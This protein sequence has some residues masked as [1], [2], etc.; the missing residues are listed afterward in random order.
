MVFF[1]W[2]N[3]MLRVLLLIV[4]L[5]QSV[6]N[7]LPR[8][9]NTP[10]YCVRKPIKIR[11]G[12][13]NDRREGGGE[14]CAFCLLVRAYYLYHPAPQGYYERRGNIKYQSALWCAC[15]MTSIL[16]QSS[17]YWL[18]TEAVVNIYWSRPPVPS[19]TA[20]SSY[21]LACGTWYLV[22]H[23]YR[24]ADTAVRVSSAVFFSIFRFLT[25]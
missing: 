22:S 12:G 18:L 9:G 3:R 24:A 14:S 21:H 5:Q 8:P 16:I 11:F 20:V 1:T 4:L 15:P 10:C 6:P 23:G 25:I 17:V 2:V 19:P 7:W 13:R